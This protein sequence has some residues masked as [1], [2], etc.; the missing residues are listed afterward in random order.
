I[1]CSAVKDVNVLLETER[2]VGISSGSRDEDFTL[3]NP[4]TNSTIL[5]DNTKSNV[6][7]AES[8]NKASGLFFSD[9][10]SRIDYVLVY[11]KSSSQSEKREIFERNIRAEGLLM[12]KEV[13]NL[14]CCFFSSNCKLR[15]VSFQNKGFKSYSNHLLQY[16]KAFLDVS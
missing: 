16:Y 11:R 4:G 7:I 6:C 1:F 5:E 10:K 8:K 2:C 9:G 3:Q 12:E 15:N 13:E 14:Y